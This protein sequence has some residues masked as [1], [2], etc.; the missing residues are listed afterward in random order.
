MI[1][2]QNLFVFRQFNRTY[3]LTS[4]F[5]N[6]HVA[7]FEGLIVSQIVNLALS[8]LE[9]AA[10]SRLASLLTSFFL[11]FVVRHIQRQS[12]VTSRTYSLGEYFLMIVIY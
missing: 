5:Y 4:F 2:N 3:T 6:H 10:E 7:A 11:T 1:T 9:V 8:Y 12:G